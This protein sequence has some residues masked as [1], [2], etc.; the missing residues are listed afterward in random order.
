MKKIIIYFL[1]IFVFSYNSA[2]SKTSANLQ[3][4]LNKD[5]L[6]FN[7]AK[8]NNEMNEMSAFVIQVVL[9]LLQH[10]ACG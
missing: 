8:G 9:V 5:I 1:F 3:K 4:N 2:L 6:H 10:T 7:M